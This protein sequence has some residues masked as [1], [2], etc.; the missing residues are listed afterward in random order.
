[1]NMY[2]ISGLGADKRVFQKIKLPEGYTPHHISWIPHRRNETLAQYARRLSAVIDTKLPFVLIGLSFGGMLAVEICRFLKPGKTIL[3]SSAA[4][5]KMLP[6]YI[7]FLKWLPLHKA[8][9]YFLLKKPTR[10]VYWLFGIRAK[11]EK[12]LFDRILYDTDISFLRWA[13]HAIITWPERKPPNHIIQIHGSEDTLLPLR[14][15]KADYVIQGGNHF[16]VYSHAWEVSAV[17]AQVLGG[18]KEE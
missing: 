13:M 4:H 14:F 18:K 2:F 16:M 10:I 8:L 9:P 7:R 11:G 15:V 1:M 6:P 17:L 3:I 12:I 5:S